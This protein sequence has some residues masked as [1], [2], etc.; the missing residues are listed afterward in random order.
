MTADGADASDLGKEERASPPPQAADL[1]RGVGRMVAFVLT[2]LP[3]ALFLAA[4]GDAK[5]FQ[6]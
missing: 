6:L 4:I 5:F 3:A 2:T 1:E